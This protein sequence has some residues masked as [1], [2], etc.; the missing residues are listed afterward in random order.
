MNVESLLRN[1]AVAAPIL[2]AVWAVKAVNVQRA[3]RHQQVFLPVVAAVYA[4]AALLLLYRFNSVFDSLVAAIF[5]FMPFLESVYQ[6]AWLYVIENI[7]ILLGFV[8][9]KRCCLAV[10]KRYATG[11]DFKGSGVVGTIYDFDVASGRWFVSPKLSQTRVLYAVIF[12]V[13][14]AITWAYT[15]MTQMALGWPGFSAIAFPAIAL[16]VVGEIYYAINGLTRSE[17]T[18]LVAGDEDSASRVVNF[19]ALRDLFDTHLNANI[20]DSGVDLAHPQHSSTRSVIESMR[21]DDAPAARLYADYFERLKREGTEL[22]ENLVQATRDVG[23]GKSVVLNTPF[24]QDLTPYVS[25][26]LHIQLLHQGTCLVIVGRDSIAEDARDWVAESLESM[27]GVPGLWDVA[28]L[29]KDSPDDLNVGVLRFSDLHNDQLVRENDEFLRNVSLVVL[30]EPSRMLITGQIGLGLVF[31]RCGKGRAPAYISIDRNHDGLVDALSHLLKVNVTDVVATPRL[32]G[33]S[34]QMAWRTDG[35]P[36]VADL[37]PEVTRYLGTGTEIAALALKYHVSK[38][39]WIGGDRFPVVDMSWIAGQYYLPINTFAELELSQRAL[40]ESFVGQSNPISGPQEENCFLV[41]ED[42][43]N[44]VYETIR[45]FATRSSKNGFVNVLSEDYLL[46]DYMVDN[47]TLFAADPKA[48]PSVVPDFVRTERNTVLRMLAE[49]CVFDVA[50]SDLRS[51]F[52]HIGIHLPPDAEER[53]EVADEPAVL[54]ALRRILAQFTDIQNFEYVRTKQLKDMPPN[55]ALPE[56][57]THFRI[58]PNA[59]IREL[60]DSLQAAYFVVEDDRDNEN[61]IGACLQGHVEQTL[62]PGQFLTFAG[63]YY[64]VRSI[65]VAKQRHEVILRRAADHITGRPAYRSLQSFD[66]KPCVSAGSL[67]S[68]EISVNDGGIQVSLIS[69]TVEARSLGY[70]A[71]DSRASLDRVR[72]V[73]LADSAVR[74]HR[75]KTVLK[76]EVEGASGAVRRT[77]ALLLNELFVTMFPIGHNFIFAVTEDDEK[78]FGDLLPD[79]IQE[80]DVQESRGSSDLIYVVEDSMID[81]GL[82]VAV[83]RNWNRLLDIVLDYLRWLVHEPVSEG[84]SAGA[85]LPRFP[86]DTDESYAERVERVEEAEQRGEYPPIRKLSRWQRFKAWIASTFRRSPK[87]KADDP[88]DQQPETIGDEEGDM[89]GAVAVE[90]G[91]VPDQPE[92]MDSALSDVGWLPAGLESQVGDEPETGDEAVS[93]SGAAAE[94]ETNEDSEYDVQK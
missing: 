33:V 9:I 93:V 37:L 19:G 62:L 22:D 5:R 47:R 79:L 90:S 4:T 80:D 20:L 55:G 60:V 10:A 83:Q 73:S 45:M 54:G 86:Q 27:V 38:V 21:S 30:I 29:G 68:D 16:I 17:A 82:V 53:E 91:H 7:I 41:V 3:V 66:V 32:T 72:K 51:E 75:N 78:T 67:Y 92:A 6:A 11:A 85:S 59:Q 89:G 74:V 88:T 77:I 46:R 65:G 71:S 31:S 26:A 87:K 8:L 24:Y 35:P 84:G 70:L 44:N 28:V 49:L 48:I 57:E 13:S 40:T 61:F 18:D 64:E 25:I 2:L 36:L 1:L 23:S 58:V 39:R 81:L 12:W 76:V 52:E 94:E 14:L 42:E 43:I 56:Q 69:A 15:A 63:K 50:E 34:S